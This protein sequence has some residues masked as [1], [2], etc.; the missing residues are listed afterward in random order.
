[1]PSSFPVTGVKIWSGAS[2]EDTT[3]YTPDI[4]DLRA[5][6]DDDHGYYWFNI[7]WNVI[8]GSVDL[9][10]YYTITEVDTKLA[11]KQNS[12]TNE[13]M[14]VVNSNPLTDDLLNKL[15]GIESGA[16]DVAI[17]NNLTTQTS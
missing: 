12:L 4:W 14:E 11:T 16:T 9:S 8:D 15:N 7:G 10:N 2:W 5:N 3:N 6:L 13:Q 1:M 17:T